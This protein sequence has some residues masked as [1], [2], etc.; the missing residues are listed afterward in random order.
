M[1]AVR[2]AAVALLIGG[3]MCA[4]TACGGEASS[5]TAAASVTPR[6]KEPASYAYTLASSGGERLLIGRFRVTVRDGRV[7]KAVGLDDSARR[8]V[9]QG[10]DAV[11]TIGDLLKE[12][13]K[14]RRD[15]A[16][17]VDVRYTADGR[18]T[19]ISLDWVANAVD[20]EAL[21]VI[22]DYGPAR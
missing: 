17:M 9:R 6:W 22:S 7:V 13:E 10:P 4:A 3:L 12:S 5:R 21:Y 20:D 19:R 16:D 15:K 1:T 2:S 11:P 8:A 18:P 14:A